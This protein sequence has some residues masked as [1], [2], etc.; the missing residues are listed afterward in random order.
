MS[1][2]PDIKEFVVFSQFDGQFFLDD[3]RIAAQALECGAQ[4]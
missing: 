2:Q 1:V 4:A 3:P